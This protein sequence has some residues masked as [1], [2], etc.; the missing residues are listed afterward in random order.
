MCR[1]RVVIALR[2]FTGA[3]A[4]GAR[5][6]HD[7]PM[8]VPRGVFCAAVAAAT[9]TTVALAP[10]TTS[11]THAVRARPAL[12]AKL[13]VEVNSLR[14]SRG[15][16]PLRVSRELAAA[17]SRHSLEMVRHGYFEHDGPGSSYARR[18][19]AH[20][21]A[22]R[23][24]RWLVGENLA[25]GSPTISAHDAVSLWLRSPKHRANLLRPSWVEAGISAMHTRAAPGVFQGRDV[26]VITLAFGGRA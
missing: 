3:V 17:A 25:W 9:L 26:T 14:V 8:P 18:L 16:A 12:E 11:A 21:P 10:A 1:E 2:L 13:L 22:G 4:S 19:K 20:Y 24:G 7:A 15:L 6:V 23:H 5:L